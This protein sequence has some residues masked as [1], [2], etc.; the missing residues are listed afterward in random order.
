MERASLDRDR[1]HAI[2]EAAGERLEGDWVLVGG[3][4]VALWVRED[5]VTEDIDL[6]SRSAEIDRRWELFDFAVEL[7][8][9]VEAINSAADFFLR[10]EP[11]WENELEL[12]HA[13]S[14]ARILRPTPTLFLLLKCGRMSE[15]DL[16]DC[17]DVSTLA[18]NRGLVLDVSRV[19]ARIDS[20]SSPSDQPGATERR[21][22][23]RRELAGG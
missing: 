15:A 22:R 8:L 5:R 12:L 6:V 17:L 14:R 16:D 9:P 7:G 2:I 23:L 21:A 19:V 18:Q 11:G 13:G 4:L 3:A 10:R 20:L 1:I